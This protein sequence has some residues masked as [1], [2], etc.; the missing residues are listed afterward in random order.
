MTNLNT[1]N[2]KA[3]V[4]GEQVEGAS[5]TTRKNYGAVIRVYAEGGNSGVDIY[6]IVIGAYLTL[7]VYK[8]YKNGTLIKQFR[9]KVQ[10]V[11][12]LNSQGV[13]N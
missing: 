2:I 13:D 12:Y 3:V 6:E 11:K 10:A 8:V 1:Q 7:P 4:N 9:T 5:M